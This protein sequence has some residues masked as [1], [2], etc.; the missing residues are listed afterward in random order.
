VQTGVA[1]IASGAEEMGM[2]EATQAMGAT[3]EERA[4]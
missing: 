2:G 3:L 1:E 4:Q